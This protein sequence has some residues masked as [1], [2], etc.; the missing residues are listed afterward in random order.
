[1]HIVLVKQK[2]L[3][4]LHSSCLRPS[5]TVSFR[6]AEHSAR[7]VVTPLAIAAALQTIFKTVIFHLQERWRTVSR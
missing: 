4:T 3:I 7:E 5:T 2:C 1:M 6:S